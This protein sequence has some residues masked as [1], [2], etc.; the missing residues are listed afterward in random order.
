LEKIRVDPV[1]LSKIIPNSG[2]FRVFS[3]TIRQFLVF[4]VRFLPQPFTQQRL[5]REFFDKIITDKIMNNLPLSDS[6][7]A[8]GRSAKE[9]NDFVGNDFVE[10]LWVRLCCA[11]LNYS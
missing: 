11:S 6:C 4:S 2:V 10:I 5:N 7:R 1:I 9:E 3:T 8:F